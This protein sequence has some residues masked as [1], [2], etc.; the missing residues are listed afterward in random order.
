M[1]LFVHMK[2]LAI[3]MGQ[4]QQTNLRDFKQAKKLSELAGVGATFSPYH[5]YD[6]FQASVS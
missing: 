6:I 1:L 4:R 3:K 5:S 2:K